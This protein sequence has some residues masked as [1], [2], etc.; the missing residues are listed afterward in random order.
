MSKKQWFTHLGIVLA[1]WGADYVTKLA[2][3]KFIK[4]VQ[5][6][7]PF[8]F[9]L[10]FNPGAM[11]GV[12]SDLPPVLRV[13]SLSTGGAFLVAIYLA[14]QYLIPAKIPSLRYGMSIL[15]GG[16]L[17]NVTD[18]IFR[19][20]VV[21]F[22]LLGSLEKAS[23]AFNVADALQWVGYLMVVYALI[24]YG[25]QFWPEDNVRR[26]MWIN[27]LFQL[28]YVLILIGVGGG[29][30]LISGVFFYT[31]LKI[32]IDELVI[33]SA[34]FY[35][36]KF[37]L[38]FFI[39]FSVITTAFILM[40]V[41]IGRVLSHRV[42]GPIYAFE[43]FLDDLLDGKSRELKLRAGDEFPHLEELA[44]TLKQRLAGRLGPED[45]GPRSLE[46]K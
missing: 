3:L 15:L 2:A 44:E 22:L 1:V 6:F 39:T 14:L 31:Y 8:G 34:P 38:P 37:L 46:K 12:F 23:P 43:K 26:K 29:F 40:L 28:R 11:L 20:S 27:P 5:F 18:R 25:S 24:R 21:D 19:G 36:R 10:H 4:A 9:V 17:G 32:V 30:T 45:P 42:A 13:V 41:V 7:G 35:E 33:G 16:I